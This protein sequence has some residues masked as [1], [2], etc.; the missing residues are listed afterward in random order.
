MKL[1][2]T[3]LIV[4]ISGAALLGAAAGGVAL[5]RAIDAGKI[6]IP[7]EL[8]GTVTLKNQWSFDL[9]NATDN[10]LR[11][12]TYKD[13][14]IKNI[15]TSTARVVSKVSLDLQGEDYFFVSDDQKVGCVGFIGENG[16]DLFASA[17]GVDLAGDAYGFQSAG[18][19]VAK[20]ARPYVDISVGLSRSGILIYRIS[21]FGYRSNK[22][23]EYIFEKLTH[24]LDKIEGDLTFKNADV[25]KYADEYDESIVAPQS[26]AAASSSAA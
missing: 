11:R 14:V 6:E 17:D 1:G 26:S 5:Q 10:E 22:K 3:I 15:D 24:S 25:A 9:E 20:G 2:K 18:G 16:S 23:S 4:L 7:P 13:G 8:T 21:D 12:L 19:V